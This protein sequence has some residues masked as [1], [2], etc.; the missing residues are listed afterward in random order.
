MGV[1]L[2]VIAAVVVAGVVIAILGWDR[3]RSG[4]RAAHSDEV[5][6]TD[7]V[8]VDPATGRRMRVWFN[9][10]TGEREYRPE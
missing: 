2:L 3:Y 9:S 10:K 5:T 8:F 7:E 6:P 1:V 4:P